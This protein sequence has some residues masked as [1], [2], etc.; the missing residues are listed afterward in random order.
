MQPFTETGAGQLDVDLEAL[1]HFFGEHS[2]K[3]LRRIFSRLSQIV[4]LLT[5]HGVDEVPDLDCEQVRLSIQNDEFSISND[6]FADLDRGDAAD[7][8]AAP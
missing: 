2:N 8:N 5:V 4:S 1:K 7:P 6:E 3:S